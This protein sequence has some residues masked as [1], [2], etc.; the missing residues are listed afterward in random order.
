MAHAKIGP[1]QVQVAIISAKITILQLARPVLRFRKRRRRTRSSRKSLKIS[2][3]VPKKEVIYPPAANPVIQVIVN[4]N[5]G[6]VK[7]V[8][9]I[10]LN[11]GIVKKLTVKK[12]A[13]KIVKT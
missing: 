4:R 2:R 8:I 6:V 3:S 5:L 11:L 12:L 9:V 10:Q 13:V 7:L 1:N